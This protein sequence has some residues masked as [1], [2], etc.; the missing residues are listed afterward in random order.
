MKKCRSLVFREWRLLQNRMKYALLLIVSFVALSFLTFYLNPGEDLSS[1]PAFVSLF[2]FA[3]TAFFCLGEEDVC[4]SD[5]KTG[6]LAYAECLPITPN[7]RA[8]ASTLFL[9]LEIVVMSIINVIGYGVNCFAAGVKMNPGLLVWGVIFFDVYVGIYVLKTAVMTF[10]PGGQEKKGRIVTAAVAGLVIICIF[11]NVFP[12]IVKMNA[13]Y[14]AQTENF[15]LPQAVVE[16]A[17][18]WANRFAFVAI[19]MLIV[20]VAAYFFVS[21]MKYE[22]EKRYE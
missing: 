14:E 13:A 17:L 2:L 6:W 8:R 20:I 3:V 5:K 4:K 9:A 11:V 19:P 21:G 10:F 1:Y 7:D 15:N 18:K 22:K 12:L 16:A